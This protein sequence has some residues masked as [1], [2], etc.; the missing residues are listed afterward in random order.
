MRKN[1]CA[2]TT[3]LLALFCAGAAAAETFRLGDWEIDDAGPSVAYCG[4]KLIAH[5]GPGFWTPGYTKG[6][7]SFASPVAHHTAE[8][9]L[10]LSCSNAAARAALAFTA[11]GKEL[12]IALDAELQQDG[13]QFEYG[14]VLPRATFAEAGASPFLHKDGVYCLLPPGETVPASGAKEL[15]FDTAAASYAFSCRTRQSFQFQDQRL[16]RDAFRWIV[17]ARAK[18]SQ[19]FRYEHVC[20]V[21]DGF[22]AAVQEAR[23]AA[24]GRPLQ[25]VERITLSNPGFEDGWTNGWKAGANHVLD[26]TTAHTGRRAARITVTDPKKD[27]VY[28]T[29]AIPVTGGARYVMSCFVKTRDVCKSERA[30]MSSV[31]AGLIVEWL[32]RNGKWMRGGE[33]ACNRYGTKDWE[34]ATCRNLKAPDEAGFAQVYL[35]L[36]GTG[37]AWFDDLEMA[38]IH[39]SPDKC[40]P[41]PGAV[42]ADNTPRFTFRATPGV[43]DWRV[44]LSRDPAF[45]AAATRVF[46]AGGFAGVQV[47]KPLES[48]RW[49]WR[50]C[51]P[52]L[53]DASPWSFVQTAPADRDTRA[54]RV[55]TRARRLTDPGAALTVRVQE[56][57]PGAPV[58][59]FLGHTGAAGPAAADGTRA[60][61]FAAPA[62]GWPK[63]FTESAITATD[64]AGNTS[65]QTFWFLV[66][67]APANAVKV[68]ADGMFHQA[69]R[70]IFPLGIYEVAPKYLAEVRAAGFDAVHQYR[71]EGSQDDAACRGY[72]D[73]CWAADGLRAFIGFDR[74]AGSGN[75]I[76]QGNFAC[77]A[78]R[79]GAL[80]DHPGLFCWYL[81]DEPEILGQYVP[82]D[83]LTAFADLVRALDPFHPVVMTTW[84]ET[85]DTYRRTWDTHWS[86]AYGDPAGVTK[87]LADQRRFLHYDSPITLLVNCNDGRQGENR[88]KGLPVD[89]AKF[90][91]DYDHLRA[92]A[93]LG[94]VKECNGVWWWWFARD[95]KDYYTAA[96]VPAAWADLVKV[97]KE[98]GALRPLVNA[99]GPVVVGTAACADG[100]KVEWWL[101]TTPDGKRTLIAVNTAAH[102]VTATLALPGGARTEVFRRHEVKIIGL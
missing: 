25:R 41:R 94:I 50:V 53:D 37:T 59:T 65:T 88:R 62:G 78:R 9:T 93:F 85:M 27:A 82:P 22:D 10:V 100:G 24:F 81:F 61:T 99:D 4:R 8:G 29:R 32:D 34:K 23:R 51:A 101:K 12:R 72:L 36:R 92:C 67:P 15:L 31:G 73:A 89:P 66:A 3:F 43:R 44:E 77:V 19:R 75:G 39:V 14:F 57:G 79:V 55:L 80:A 87:L 95:T 76:V 91:R 42:F 60:Y 49:H 45:P 47:D 28:L 18:S 11:R 54:P 86:Q 26:E 58:V 98:I 56:E 35:T 64:A 96:Q 20:T 84:N 40:A 17:A 33:Y 71:W 69:G 38:R 1:G 13:G 97:V 48:G 5:C 74:G 83:L 46:P 90:A 70:R 2:K 102:A 68:E 52:G 16:S 7:F 6:I 21:E 63:G 30:A